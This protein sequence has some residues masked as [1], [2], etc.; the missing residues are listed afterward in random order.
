M[1]K[2]RYDFVQKL[3]NDIFTELEKCDSDCWYANLA[4]AMQIFTGCW[5]QTIGTDDDYHDTTDKVEE[6]LSWWDK[7][8]KAI[9]DFFAKIAALFGM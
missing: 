4:D 2:D 9:K 3:L 7:F 8:I 1:F 5:K 6:N